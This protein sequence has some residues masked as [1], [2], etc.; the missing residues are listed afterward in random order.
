[1]QKDLMLFFHVEAY[2]ARKAVKSYVLVRTSS[3]NKIKTK[4]KKI[5]T[6]FK[7]ILKVS[8][9]NIPN[10]KS[11]EFKSNIYLQNKRKKIKKSIQIK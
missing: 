3:K 6:F 9:R 2:V 10:P 8:L 7:K 4:N 1:M 11:K 5:K